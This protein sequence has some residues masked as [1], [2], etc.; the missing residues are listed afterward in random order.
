[1]KLKKSLTFGVITLFS[2]TTL[3]ACEAAERQIAQARLVAVRQVAN[4]FYVSQNN[5]KCQQLIYH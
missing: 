5:K 3:A 2:V 4:K 1:M